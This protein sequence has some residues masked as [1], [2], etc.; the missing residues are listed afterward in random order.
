MIF[1]C[2]FSFPFTALSFALFPL[3]LLILFPLFSRQ[4]FYFFPFHPFFLHI[5]LALPLFP[6]PLPL[7]SLPP[8]P[9]SIIL[10]LSLNLKIQPRSL[11]PAATSRATQMDFGSAARA[12]RLSLFCSFIHAFHLFS[13]AL[14]YFV[15][16][17]RF[18][19]GFFVSSVLSTF[20]GVCVSLFRHLLLFFTISLLSYSCAIIIFCVYTLLLF[21]SFPTFSFFHFFSRPVLSLS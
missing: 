12:L 4:L 6:L 7:L 14:W 15:L 10:F 16:C 19:L 21:L 9:I 13:F 20:L 17:F 5:P 8:P 3:S 1:P 18:F 2:I 11:S